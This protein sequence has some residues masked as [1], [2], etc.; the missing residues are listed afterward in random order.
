[1]Y[2]LP[3]HHVKCTCQ[4]MLYRVSVLLSV[5]IINLK[6]DQTLYIY[7]YISPKFI[8]FIDREVEISSIQYEHEL[9]T[10]CNIIAKELVDWCATAVVLNLILFS[11]DQRYIT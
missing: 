10:S 3:L 11:V 8:E 5:T 7:I 9:P 6:L 4:P 2:I 1:M